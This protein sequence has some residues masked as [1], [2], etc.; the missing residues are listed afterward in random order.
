[1]TA[2]LESFFARPEIS[3]LRRTKRGEGEADIRPAIKDIKFS[4]NGDGSVKLEASISAQEPTLNPELLVSA[5]RQLDPQL[6]PDF[7]E[8]TRLETFDEKMQVFR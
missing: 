1:M 7:A 2:R 5:L 3:I 4:Y 6:A 8:F